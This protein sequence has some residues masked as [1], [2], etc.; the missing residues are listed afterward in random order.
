M[1]AMIVFLLTSAGV[2]SS[3]DLPEVEEVSGL[4]A[5]ALENRWGEKAWVRANCTD[6]WVH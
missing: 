1:L 3:S 2:S 5:I 4:D 6:N